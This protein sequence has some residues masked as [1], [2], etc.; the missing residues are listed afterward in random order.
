MTKERQLGLITILLPFLVQGCIEPFEPETV[1]FESRLVVEANITNESKNQLV[2]IS[3]TFALD[4]TGVYA[5]ENA[6]VQVM[7]N[8]ESTYDFKDQG[9]G[10]YVSQTAF[11]A[12]AG[13]GYRLLFTTKDGDEYIS[14]EEIAPEPTKIHRIY[15][16]RGF[17]D[18][19]ANEG[20][21]IYLD[22]YDPTGINK[23]Y[24]YEYEETYK[25]IAPFWNA[26][27]LYI[28]NPLPALEVAL[29]PKEREERICFGTNVSKAIIQQNITNFKET[30]IS[31]FPVRFINKENYILSY[32]YSNLI[33]QHVQTAE[34]YAYYRA[35]NDLASNGSI[36]SQIQTGFLEGNIRSKENQDRLVIGFFEVSSI[37]QKRLF[38]NYA[39]FFP[40][41]ELPNYIGECVFYPIDPR[42]NAYFMSYAIETA[43]HKYYGTGDGAENDVRPTDGDTGAEFLMVSRICGDCTILGSNVVPNFWEEE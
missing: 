8:D 26:L 27:D 41:E 9:N 39:D 23:Y 42:A 18:G 36:F 13:L 38:F 22:S 5:E 28:R 15:A 6:K 40:D 33:K 31:G 37:S 34:A 35:L 1:D 16:E 19:G 17:K 7:V 43:G 14:E 10:T 3:R 29:R 30:R 12:K 20:M 25:I 32:R 21:F 2:K 11:S 4:T 24:R